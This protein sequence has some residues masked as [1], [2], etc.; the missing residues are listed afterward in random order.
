MATLAV[1]FSGRE[2]EADNF[3]SGGLSARAKC[4]VDALGRG[5]WPEID[6]HSRT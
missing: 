5:I 3:D 1:A 2:K 6:T 4:R